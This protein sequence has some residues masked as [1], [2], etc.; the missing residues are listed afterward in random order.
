MVCFQQFRASHPR[1]LLIDS[2]SATVQIGLWTPDRP[3]VWSCGTGEAGEQI[4]A[5]VAEAT[6]LAGTPLSA[7]D[8]FIFCDGPGS[9]LGIRTAAVALRTWSVLRERPSYGYCGLSAVAHHEVARGR[10][11]F[12]VIADARRD[13]WHQVEVD[14]VGSVGALK[15]VPSPALQGTLLTPNGFRAWSQPPPLEIV[16]Y[17][18]AEILPGIGQVD[19][20]APTATPD[21]FLHEE[22]VYQM[23]TPKVHQAPASP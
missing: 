10:R 21:A 6:A 11:S 20:F 17:S 7:I 1:L 2:A 16:S 23:W 3:P 19:L 18:L 4:F 14:A 15:R 8:A 12:A 13:S 5:R 9:V 22:P